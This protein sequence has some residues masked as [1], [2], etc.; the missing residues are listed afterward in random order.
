MGRG[1]SG[2]EDVREVRDGVEGA[3]VLEVLEVLLG[4]LGSYLVRLPS[5]AL[6]DRP[7]FLGLERVLM[8]EA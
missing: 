3:S 5:M 4:L 7:D 1:T 6:I 8:K 2:V